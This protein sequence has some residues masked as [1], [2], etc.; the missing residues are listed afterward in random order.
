[1]KNNDEL[2]F[3][4]DGNI[5]G[6]VTHTLLIGKYDSNTLLVDYSVRHPKDQYHE[7]KRGVIG[8]RPIQ[9]AQLSLSALI[10]PKKLVYVGKKSSSLFLDSQNIVMDSLYHFVTIVKKYFKLSHEKIN[11]VVCSKHSGITYILPIKV[12]R[13]YFKK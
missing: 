7:V 9:K 2:L 4:V 5:D 6:E 11:V 3:H 12:L 8:K 10:K 1:M 13:K